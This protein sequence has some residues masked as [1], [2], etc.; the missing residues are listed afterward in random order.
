MPEEGKELSVDLDIY[1]IKRGDLYGVSH[2][3]ENKYSY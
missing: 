3:Y 1:S 2:R